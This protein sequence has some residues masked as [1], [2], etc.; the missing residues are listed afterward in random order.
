MLQPDDA[1][2]RTAQHRTGHVQGRGGRRP[3]GDHERIGQW[4]PTLEVRDLALD[5]TG[6]LGR[7]DHEVLLQLVVLGGIGRELGADRE[8]LALDPEDDRVPA[9]VPDQG[10]RHA[11]RRDCLVDG[12]VRLG[13]RV[14]LGDAAAVEQAGLSRISGLR[15]DALSRDGNPYAAPRASTSCVQCCSTL[16]W[17]ENASGGN[18]SGRNHPT[19]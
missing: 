11:E 16:R 3:T 14:R 5:A 13:A 17:L 9:P 1:S 10:A 6:E 15:D 19:C 8:Q 18:A 7:Y 12:P 4:N 2:F